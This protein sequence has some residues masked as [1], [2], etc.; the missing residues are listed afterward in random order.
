MWDA[1]FERPLAPEFIDEVAEDGRASGRG[2]VRDD[3]YHLVLL[4]KSMGH[5]RISL[6]DGR[7]KTRREMW[8]AAKVVGLAVDGY[9]P[10]TKAMRLL[11]ELKRDPRYT[12]LGSETT[13]DQA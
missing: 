5:E 11:T 12:A 2:S 10:D 6:T 4:H 3:A 8:A 13:P 9:T 1:R 7:K